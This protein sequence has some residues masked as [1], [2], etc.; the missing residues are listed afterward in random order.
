MTRDIKRI[1]SILRKLGYLW[2]KHQDYR[3]GQLL[4][5]HN[6]VPDDFNVWNNEDD[7]LEKHLDAH[8]K[9]YEKEAKKVKKK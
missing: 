9:H 5:N 3:F 4:I 2:V 8:L 7:G 6:I 1:E